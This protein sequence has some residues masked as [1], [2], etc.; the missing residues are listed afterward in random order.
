MQQWARILTIVRTVGCHHGKRVCVSK[1][2]TTCVE[3][4]P[5]H[6][7]AGQCKI[8]KI[9]SGTNV[10]TYN[11][12]DVIRVVSLLSLQHATIHS[13]CTIIHHGP[14]CVLQCAVSYD[15]QI[16]SSTVA[17]VNLTL[18][19]PSL[20]R[21]PSFQTRG[22]FLSTVVLSSALKIDKY[23]VG[24]TRG[25]AFFRFNFNPN[26]SQEQH[27]SRSCRHRRIF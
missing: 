1:I 12:P 13:P 8:A 7:N 6:S 19:R 20:W 10:D 16:I 9:H 3:S 11:L 15:N 21:L 14:W 25:L 4:T 5:S 2:Q 26:L 27:K 22:S 24:L 23:G 17:C 18:L